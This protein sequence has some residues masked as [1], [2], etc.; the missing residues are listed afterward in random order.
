MRLR[1]RAV[2]LLTLANAAV[3]LVFG[4]IALDEFGQRNEA[5]RAATRERIRELATVLGPLL[6]EA[7]TGAVGEDEDSTLQIEKVLSWPHWSLMRDA[8]LMDR[9]YTQISDE[10]PV[11]SAGGGLCLNPVGLAHRTA[12][13]DLGNVKRLIGRAMETRAVQTGEGGIAIPVM[14]GTAVRGGVYLRVSEPETSTASTLGVL[15]AFVAS[16][17]ALSAVVSFVVTTSVVKPVENLARVGREVV[18]GNLQAEPAPH[19]SEDEMGDLTDS[20]RA[21]L[22]TLRR[23]GQ[24]MERAA[25]LA[26]ERATK[27]ER[28]LLV[29]QRLASM[30]TLAAG[31]A[32]EINNPLGGLMNAVRRLQKGD[33]H[34]DRQQEYYELVLDGLERIR[35]IVGRTLSMAPKGVAAVPVSIPDAAREAMAFAKH[36][37]D[38]EGIELLLEAAGDEPLAVL[39]DRGELVQVFLNLILN[40]IDALAVRIA[41]QG[42]VPPP[43]IRMVISREADALVASVVDNGTGVDPALLDRILDPFFSTKE[44]GKGTGLGLTVVF[45]IV[46]NHG[47]SLR[48]ANVAGGGF[49][50]VMRMPC[51]PAP[52]GG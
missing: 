15:V 14:S 16:T 13:F 28:D 35:A 50:V 4:T 29:T 39:G 6:D 3:F 7:L 31:I 30:G 26:A 34:P 46:R 33:L 20:M 45:A 1:T 43:R 17:M 23:H 9:R 44:P 11:V 27:A 25:T 8:V 41:A 32:H 21:M 12:E 40:S 47:G 18:A 51:A 10:G 22:R 42:R 5:A 49:E 19:A 2:L 37:A 48:V 52:L 24:E 38:R 36:R